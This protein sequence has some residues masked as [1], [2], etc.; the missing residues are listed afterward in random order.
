VNPRFLAAQAHTLG[1]T[2][3]A[4]ILGFAV[5]TQLVTGASGSAVGCA[6]SAAAYT[7]VGLVI[8]VGIRAV[9]TS[10]NAAESSAAKVLWLPASI[11]WLVL[12]VPVAAFVAP[13]Y[14]IEGVGANVATVTIVLVIDFLISRASPWRSA[15][16]DAVK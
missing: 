16:R 11:T 13:Q 4:S 8:D 9:S 7:F 10:G 12:G 2:F 3:V 15:W 5:A 6:A 1:I 14:R